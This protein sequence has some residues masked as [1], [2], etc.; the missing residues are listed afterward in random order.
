VAQLNDDYRKAGNLNLITRFQP[1]R[2]ESRSEMMIEFSKC[3]KNEKRPVYKSRAKNSDLYDQRICSG[4]ADELFHPLEGTW[5]WGNCWFVCDD[6]NHVP[7][8]FRARGK[9]I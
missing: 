2:G 4:S 8:N 9:F 3:I 5:H 7:G 6:I 1:S